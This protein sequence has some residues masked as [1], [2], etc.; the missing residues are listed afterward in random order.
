M[1][2]EGLE[3]GQSDDCYGVLLF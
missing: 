1:S 2:A 3:V